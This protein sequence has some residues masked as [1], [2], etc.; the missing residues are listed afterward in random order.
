MV[1]NRKTD[2]LIRQRILGLGAVK[3]SVCSPCMTQ[4]I[5]LDRDNQ[6]WAAYREFYS[7]DEMF[8]NFRKRENK[9]VK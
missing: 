5:Y 8:W 1:T 3:V 2:L 9:C 6:I 7:A 4:Y